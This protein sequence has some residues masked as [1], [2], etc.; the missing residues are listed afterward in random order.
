MI[1]GLV[2]RPE[3]PVAV[4]VQLAPVPADQVVEVSGFLARSWHAHP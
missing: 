4:H 3:H 1:F 2:K